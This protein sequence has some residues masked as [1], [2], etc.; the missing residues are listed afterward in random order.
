MDNRTLPEMPLEELVYDQ[1]NGFLEAPVLPGVRDESKGGFIERETGV[2]YEA[3]DR[4]RRRF[5]IPEEDRDLEA[6]L[7][8]A[9]RLCHACALAMFRHGQAMPAPDHH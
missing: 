5:S 7:N 1:M 2:L 9:E 4:L 3:R 6:M 8:A